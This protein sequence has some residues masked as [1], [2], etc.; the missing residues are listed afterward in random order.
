MTLQRCRVKSCLP[1]R[2]LP[3]G[4]RITSLVPWSGCNCPSGLDSAGELPPGG[5]SGTGPRKPGGPCAFDPWGGTGT[6][7]Q[8]RSDAHHAN[9]FRGAES[10][11]AGRQ[12]RN[13]GFRPAGTELGRAARLPVVSGP[14]AVELRM[15]VSTRPPRLRQRGQDLD[16][17]VETSDP[18]RIEPG[19]VRHW[20]RDGSHLG[21][22]GPRRARPRHRGDERILGPCPH[23]RPTRRCRPRTEP[24]LLGGRRGDNARAANRPSS[25]SG[26]RDAKAGQGARRP[27][28]RT[29]CG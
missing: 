10:C 28:G 6:T 22:A 14:A 13:Q 16:L 23:G 18:R 17:V 1:G 12:G 20:I 2:L 11:P 26:P 19:P 3:R 7:N 9:S 21:T 29:R 8:G 5:R 24:R 25:A 15:A 4:G 27:H